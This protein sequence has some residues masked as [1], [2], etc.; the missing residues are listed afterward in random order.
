MS[1]RVSG[2][3][4]GF[5]S[6]PQLRHD[7]RQRSSRRARGKRAGALR[8]RS[9]MIPRPPSE[10]LARPG[11]AALGQ[12]ATAGGV[13]SRRSSTRASS[14]SERAS[15]SS[16]R[17]RFVAAR[18]PGGPQSPP[19]R[20][21]SGRL[22]N[23]RSRSPRLTP[24]RLGSRLP[25]REPAPAREERG[26]A[27][28]AILIGH[29]CWPPPYPSST[30]GPLHGSLEPAARHRLRTQNGAC[31][32]SGGEGP[33]RRRWRG[34]ARWARCFGQVRQRCPQPRSRFPRRVRLSIST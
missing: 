19:G 26:V 7:R 30:R 24:S 28:W 12:L 11:R 25:A 9:V 13:A 8:E 6:R 4:E 5:G 3:S 2:P 23:T 15:S 17:P 22:E 21:L 32:S 14:A 20:F 1:S 29:P 33:L 18:R 27:A 34:A 10:A 16:S 31:A